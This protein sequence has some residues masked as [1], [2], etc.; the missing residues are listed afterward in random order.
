MSSMCQGGSTEDEAA[1]RDSFSFKVSFRDFVCFVGFVS[2][3][4]LFRSGFPGVPFV[5]FFSGFRLFRSYMF[6]G[7]PFVGFVSGFRLFR[8]GFSVDL[9]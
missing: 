1:V 9:L 5:C 8:S 6:S 7:V 2:G 3:F 4:R